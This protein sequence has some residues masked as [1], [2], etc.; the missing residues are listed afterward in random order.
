M[1]QDTPQ[2]PNSGKEPEN[3]PQAIVGR[4]QALTDQARR[5]RQAVVVIHGIGEQRPMD[6]LRGFVDAVLSDDTAS[7]GKYRNKPDA[8]NELFET[9]CLQ[10]PPNHQLHRPLTDY[11]EYYWAHHMQGSK[12]THVLSWLK[13]VLWRRPAMIPPALRPVYFGSWTLILL[14]A[15][16]W[17]WGLFDAFTGHPSFIEGLRRQIRPFSGGLLLLLLQGAGSHLV[18]KYLADAARYL[19]PSPDNIDARVKIRGEGIKLLRT[20]HESGKYSRIVVVGHSLGSV[21][22]YDIIR[23]LWVE[24]RKPLVPHPRKQPELQAFE[25]VIEKLEDAA[26]TPTALDDYQRSQHDLWK[27][28]RAAGIPWLITDFITLGAPLTHAQLLM[29]DNPEDFTR[30]TEEY[31]YPICPPNMDDPLYYHQQY[32]M[33][34]GG[35]D[36]IRNVYI[37]NHGAPFA[38]TRWTNLYFPYSKLIFGDLVGGPLNGVFGKGVRDLAVA[39]STDRFLAGTLMSHTLYWTDGGRTGIKTSLEVLRKALRLDFLRK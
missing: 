18:L 13:G 26:V 35:E 23:N 30:K 25:H 39:P 8:M 14:I 16:L 21:I 34:L 20:L 7:G 33:N 2:T 31:E 12:Y 9:R 1:E 28:F 10:S 19:T 3:A 11:Y 32:Q 5:V 24:M 37:P 4:V 15:S 38:C 22:G 29:A 27:E 6:T 17:G 36:V